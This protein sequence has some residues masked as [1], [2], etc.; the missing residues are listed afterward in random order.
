MLFLKTDP[1]RLTKAYLTDTYLNDT[2]RIDCE[3]ITPRTVKKF[4][5]K[6]Q[7]A[8]F[9][10]LS[11][12]GLALTLSHA[13]TS[14]SAK[15][16]SLHFYHQDWEVACD[17]TRTCRA[18][19][20]QQ[21]DG[22][23][24]PVSVLLTRKAGAQQPV[25]SQVKLGSTDYVEGQPTPQS[26]DLLVN[27]KNYGKVVLE[28]GSLSGDLTQAQTR[29]LLTALAG[30]SVI[31]FRSGKVVWRLSDVGAA[32]V[33]LK[34][35]DAQ[36]RVGSSG[37][38]IKKG[39]KPETGVLPALPMPVVQWVKPAA[40]S[41]G[42]KQLV[43]A[44]DLNQLKKQL[45]LQQSK[46]NDPVTDDECP[47]MSGEDEYAKFELQLEPLT[48]Q[49]LLVSGLCWRGAYNEGYGYWVINAQPPYQPQRVT[50]GA[51]DY[52]DGIISAD[53]KGRGLGDCW[54][55][56]TWTW[57]GQQFIHSAESTTGMCRMIELGGAWE[58]PTRV[59]LVKKA[60]LATTK[61]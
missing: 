34:M 19:G 20:Y 28:S 31:Q 27:A 45:L 17:N 30:K 47:V 23:G 12:S 53:Q 57:N 14:A 26:V 22:N 46:S 59:T 25:S 18:A 39:Q 24:F 61:K 29:A 54:S 51:S 38:L 37:A 9:M 52:A 33:L 36:G 4:T 1:S 6:K 41:A 15:N 58:L 43:K 55:H 7:I 56:Q 16:Q 8:Q 49:K 10:L 60:V 48:P 21:D 42:L 50:T 13:A 44:V 5:I 3:V 40:P 32:A 11:L 2:D 35:D